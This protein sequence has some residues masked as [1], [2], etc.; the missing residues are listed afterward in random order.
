MQPQPRIDDYPLPLPT[1]SVSAVQADRIA[2][3]PWTQDR[4][5]ERLKSAARTLR[6]LPLPKNGKPSTMQAAWP[7]IVQ[8]WLA[9]GWQDARLA[10]VQPS[11][12][13]IDEL[14]ETLQWLH[15]LTRD[16]R[17]VLW[18]RAQG[19]TWRQLEALDDH[20]RPAGKRGRR[21]QTLRGI[22]GDAEAR[23]LS[24]LNGTPGRMVLP[25]DRKKR[26]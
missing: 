23:I 22:C 17:M 2:D 3:I 12:A 7:E 26:A 1:K 10:R 6:H 24:K 9:Y 16:Q 4:L 5:R 18:G 8:D 14:D 11:A 19:W 15:W 20:T 13:Q 25:P 21:E